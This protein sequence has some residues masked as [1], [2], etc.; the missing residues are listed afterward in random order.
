MNVFDIDSYI[1]VPVSNNF[2]VSHM[3]ISANIVHLSYIL[4]PHLQAQIWVGLSGL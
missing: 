4:Y 1:F 2:R 3:S